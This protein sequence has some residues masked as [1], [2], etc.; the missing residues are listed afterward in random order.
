MIIGGR[1]VFSN[2]RVASRTMEKFDQTPVVPNLE[3]VKEVGRPFK[4][5]EDDLFYR[6]VE[7]LDPRANW[8]LAEQIMKRYQ[9]GHGTV[10]KLAKMGVIDPAMEL[11][12]PTKR[13]RVRDDA[14][15]KRVIADMK[16]K[17]QTVKKARAPRKNPNPWGKE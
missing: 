4:D 13:Y 5:E 2:V 15:L 6:V 12:S 1:A 7:Y 11:A 16:A 14:T 10:L 17:L 3:P 8:M 9:I